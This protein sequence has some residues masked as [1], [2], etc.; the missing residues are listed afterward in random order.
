MVALVR[1]FARRD[2]DARER[3]VLGITSNRPDRAAA[4]HGEWA[5]LARERPM[6]RRAMVRQL[7]AASRYRIRAELASVPVLVLSGD[8]DRLVSPAS[9]RALAR[10]IG[11]DTAVH[12][13]GGHDLPLD[14]PDW[15]LD[16]LARFTEEAGRPTAKVGS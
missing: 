13:D 3:I 6:R 16:Q 5:R 2:P 12:P 15:V 7:V 11:A 9:S 1:A 8:D 14:D 10:A 4:V